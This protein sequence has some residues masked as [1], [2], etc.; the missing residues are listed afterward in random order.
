MGRWFLVLFGH[1]YRKSS[2]ME[3][4]KGDHRVPLY[5]VPCTLYREGHNI[6]IRPHLPG[7]RYKAH[8][9]RYKVHGTKYKSTLWSPFGDPI[10]E[11]FL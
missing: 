3:S 1:S 6:I 11:L 10:L 5:L 9:A 7:T 2:K 4:P 8:G